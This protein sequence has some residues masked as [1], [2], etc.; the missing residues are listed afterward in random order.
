MFSLFSRR[1]SFFFFP[2]SETRNRTI[3]L[4]KIARQH[5]P[6]SYPCT[7]RP[8]QTE[9]CKFT[10]TQ[11]CIRSHWFGTDAS[12]ILFSNHSTCWHGTQEWARSNSSHRYDYALE[13][14][15]SDWKWIDL[16]RVQYVCIT[17]MILHEQYMS[18]HTYVHTNIH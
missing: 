2:F 5:Q 1:E 17:C 9:L 8:K 15:W 16:L 13:M 11:L 14:I 7:T 3:T 10:Y 4:R 18:Y 6:S 12:L